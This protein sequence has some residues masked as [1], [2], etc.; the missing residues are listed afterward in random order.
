MNSIQ[1]TYAYYDGG[2]GDCGNGGGGG[3][4]T[5]SMLQLIH[6]QRNLHGPVDENN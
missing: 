2:G 5:Y 3:R 6:K 1:N 4:G